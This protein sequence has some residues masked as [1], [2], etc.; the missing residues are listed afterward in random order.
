MKS[1]DSTNL[2]ETVIASGAASGYVSTIPTTQATSGDGTISLTLGSPPECAISV[3]AGGKR[4]LMKDVNGVYKLL[5]AA[6][7]SVQSW[8]ILPF[9]SDFATAIGGY[10]EG[11]I[12]ADGEGTL[13][14]STADDNTTTPGATDADWTEILD[15]YITESAA[16]ERYLRNSGNAQTSSSPT[17]FSNGLYVNTTSDWTSTQV[18]SMSM[19]AGYSMRLAGTAQSCSSPTTF[20]NGLT[21]SYDVT[22]WTTNA[23][24]NAVTIE[25]NFLSKA[26]NDQLSSSPTT[27]DNGLW[28]TATFYVS[29]MKAVGTDAGA[30]ITL[31]SDMRCGSQ[32]VYVNA[33]DIDGTATRTIA[34]ATDVSEQWNFSTTPEVNGTN[35][36]LGSEFANGST[37]SSGYYIRVGN[38]LIQQF[39]ASNITSTAQWITFPVE[40]SDTPAPPTGNV[41]GANDQDTQVYGATSSGCYVKCP[42]GSGNQGQPVSITVMGPVS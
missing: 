16:D 1:T 21:S 27:F 39:E 20:T 29:L 14:Y 34:G 18:P 37:G 25:A 30:Y 28:S 6:I 17:T 26:G 19:V 5:S 4:P 12:C 7:Q 15:G 3:A 2:I 33:M 10:P 11:A 35:V 22:D 31:G 36:A 23:V 42:V 41:Y 24:P 40:F 8:G 38:T 13:W 32:T 9:S